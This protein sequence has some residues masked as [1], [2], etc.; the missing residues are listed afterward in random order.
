[1]KTIAA[2][3]VLIATVVAAF[4]LLHT[5]SH[6]SAAAAAAPTVDGHTITSD[7]GNRTWTGSGWTATYAADVQHEDTSDTTCWFE[8]VSTDPELICG[9]RGLRPAVDTAD[10]VQVHVD[11]ASDAEIAQLKAHGAVADPT[12]HC[13]CLY[14]PAVGA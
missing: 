4:L 9:D 13:A 2:T 10:V 6:V 3:L 1:M 12:G 7:G 11:D 8:K 14:V 5:S